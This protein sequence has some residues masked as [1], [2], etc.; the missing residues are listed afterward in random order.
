MW[1]PGEPDPLGGG[2]V[3]P[4]LLQHGGEEE[5]AFCLFLFFG[6]RFAERGGE[7][8]LER[9]LDARVG[10]HEVDG[11]EQAGGLVIPRRG[12]VHDPGFL[13]KKEEK[14]GLTLG[15]GLYRIITVVNGVRA[16]VHKPL[17]TAR[18]PGGRSAIW[19]LAVLPGPG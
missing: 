7:A 2:R 10:R 15:H 8:W 12:F 9:D 3:G 13:K 17:A 1:G 14:Q 16:S 19:L 18:R 5:A 6:V 11:E 4:A